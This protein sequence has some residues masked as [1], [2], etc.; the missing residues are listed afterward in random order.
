MAAS[1]ISETMLTEEQRRFEEA[2][3]RVDEADDP[4]DLFY[5]YV[6][7][8]ETDSK[9]VAL[10]PT[11]MNVLERALRYLHDDLRYQ[12]DPRF[13]RLWLIYAE[14]VDDPFDIY[15][16]LESNGIGRNVALY[17][18]DLSM[19]YESYGQ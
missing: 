6:E 1:N 18:E 12:N 13:V 7:S 5:R 9:A 2:L 10:N 15:T 14:T 16:Y 8:L 19:L 17:Y 3:E 11:L 4:L